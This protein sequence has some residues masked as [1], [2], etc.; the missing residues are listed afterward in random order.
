M[1]K[2]GRKWSGVTL[3]S[4]MGL[5]AA[6]CAILAYFLDSA[7]LFALTSFIAGIVSHILSGL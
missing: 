1:D 2:Y 3:R 5:F 7:E 6:S 4:I